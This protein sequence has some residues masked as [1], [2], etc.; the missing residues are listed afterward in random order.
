MAVTLA[1]HPYRRDHQGLAIH[2]D[3]AA[4]AND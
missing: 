2:G 4:A 1:D 3:Y